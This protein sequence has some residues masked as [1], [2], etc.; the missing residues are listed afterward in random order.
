MEGG[1]RALWNLMSTSAAEVIP[2]EISDGKK[3]SL[4]WL[5]VQFQR[6]FVVVALQSHAFASRC[7]LEIASIAVE[8]RHTF[9]I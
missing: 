2:D 4:L 6:R 1:Y 5:M 3:E 9:P 8:D 7:R